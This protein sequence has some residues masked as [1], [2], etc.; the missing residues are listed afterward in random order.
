M[1]NKINL[2]RVLIANMIVLIIF[3]ALVLIINYVEYQKYTKNF[4]NKI[5]LILSKIVNKYPNVE[6]NELIELLNN[7]DTLLDENNILKHYGID[8]KKDSAVLKNEGEF[9]KFEIL[10]L[11]LLI[12]LIIN[13]L[14][15]IIKYSNNNSK[16]I[17]EITKYIE[18]INRRNYKLDIEENSEDELSILKNEIYKTTVMLNEI[19]ENETKDK[20]ELKESLSDISHQ[21]KTPLTS[22]IIM[23]DNILDN[24]EMSQEVREEFIKDI[25]REITNIQ[26]L[27]ETLLKLSKLDANSVEFINKEV[28]VEEIIQNAV[29]NVAMICDL[30]NI[31]INITGNSKEKLLCDERWQI[32][33]ITNILKNA[34]EHSKNNS[35][36]DIR[37]N[38]N[39]AYTKITIK[40]YG[41][42]I[43]EKDLKH[44][45]ERFY[46][47]KNASKDSVGIGLALAKAIIEKNNGY[48]IV[49]SK[50]N[51]GT[52]F[53]I[54]YSTL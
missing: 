48:I 12:L 29:K 54:K 49:T 16:K 51:E 32:E 6:K 53:V 18:Q 10:L 35:Q 27:I 39:K 36:I 24:K 9:V 1:K 23:L 34:A 33:A 45:F 41:I 22:I 20:K 50:E 52:T 47:G 8:I 5:E 46:K 13:I 17:N 42:G 28:E 40:D 15:I 14:I 31:K 7:E 37:Y 19:A 4:N 38:Q 2:K 44:I 43:N 3:S 21:L 11:I 30:K 26:F 25:K